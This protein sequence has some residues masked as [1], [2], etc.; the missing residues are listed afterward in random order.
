MKLLKP[1]RIFIS[2]VITF[3]IILI[4]ADIYKVIPVRFMEA[5]VSSQFIPS[6]L[7]FTVKASIAASGF[8]VILILTFLTG[9]VYCSFIC[10]LGFFQDV[11]I[12]LRK[13]IPR[14]LGFRY[15]KPHFILFYG[16]LALTIISFIIS[17]TFLIMLLD[18]FS[19]SGRFISYCASY[20]L[21]DANNALAA[22]LIKKDIYFI[23]SVDAKPFTSIAFYSLFFFAIIMGLSIA[24]GRLYCNTIC[25]AGAILSLLARISIFRIRI[26]HKK[27]INCGRC[28]KSCKSGCIDYQAHHVDSARCISCFNCLS[29]CPNGSIALSKN[30]YSENSREPEEKVKAPERGTITRLSFLSGMILIPQVLRAKEKA[31]ATLYYQEPL[32]QKKYKRISF[33][34]PPG[35][36]SIER[37]NSR[38]T[39]C[40]LCISACPT[41]VLQP[42]VMQYG[43]YGVMQPYMDFETGFCNY[44]CTICGDI[45]PADAITRNQLDSKRRIQTG[46]SVFVKENCITVTNGTDCGACSEHCPT[47]AVHMIPYKNGLV[48]PEVNTEICTG[49]GA[50]EYACPVRPLKAI[51]VNGNTVHVTAKLPEQKQNKEKEKA[52]FPF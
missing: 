36:V 38:C 42:A 20:P 44:D 51:Y 43:L 21:I 48:I 33:S 22:F 25:P 16:I 27:C 26:D 31:P 13:V 50:C 47:K 46:K 3:S 17:G 2:A 32:K 30:L 34:S 7:S 41:S 8:L 9:R 39:A 4:F 11:F 19:V 23:H 35:S 5:I 40:S 10:P 28:E 37:F 15:Q 18:P 29:V 24:K 52:A 1:L 12:R 14:A 49:C 6:I 45:C